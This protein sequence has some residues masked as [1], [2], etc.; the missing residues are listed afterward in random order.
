MYS[1]EAK[2]TSNQFYFIKEEHHKSLWNILAD[3][4]LK[5]YTCQRCSEQNDFK[6][7]LI[8]HLYQIVKIQMCL[9]WGEHL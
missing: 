5:L 6:E 9:L 1:K 7:M 8:K 4:L 3:H 2:Y